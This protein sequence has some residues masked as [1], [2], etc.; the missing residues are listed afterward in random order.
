MSGMLGDLARAIAKSS[1]HDHV[2][3][4]LRDVPG[5]PPMVQ[6]V[7]I[8]SVAIIMGSIV[9]IDL[10]VLGVAAPSQNPNEMIRRLLP[11]MWTALALL[12]LSG[13]M[14]VVTRPARYFANPIFG[15]KFALLLSALALSVVLVRLLRNSSQTHA[16][17]KVVAALSMLLWIGVMFAGRWIAYADYI[18]PPPD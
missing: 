2:L 3:H 7:H 16:G 12:F 15:I 6:T 11:W 9:M 14:F 5:L 8:L 17:A 10:R 18:F 4:W 1:L 13:S